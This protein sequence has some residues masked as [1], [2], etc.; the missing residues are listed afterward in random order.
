MEHAMR[1]LFLSVC[2]AAGLVISPVLAD[3][4]PRPTSDPVLTVSGQIEN[5]NV[6]QKAVFDMAMLETMPEQSFET[7][8]LWTDGK[9]RFAGVALA[10][11]LDAIGAESGVIRA[12]AI[13]DYTVEIPLDSVTANAPIIAYKMNGE[14][15]SRRQKGPLWIVYPYDSDAAFRTEVTYSRSIWQLDRME[16][17]Q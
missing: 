12:S 10:D 4:I 5:M 3:D 16:I 14:H 9:T 8:T 17:V 15:M 11:V 2:L 7:T 1:T 13:N 6:A